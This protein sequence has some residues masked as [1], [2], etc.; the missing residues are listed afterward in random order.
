[1]R[2]A[3]TPIL[4][5]RIMRMIPGRSASSEVVLVVLFWPAAAPS[6]PAI[7]SDSVAGAGA[8]APPPSCSGDNQEGLS[9]MMNV[10]IRLV[11]TAMRAARANNEAAKKCDALSVLGRGHSRHVR[12]CQNLF[13][14]S[15]DRFLVLCHHRLAI[16]GRI[17]MDM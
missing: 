6:F 9:D 17:W 3:A 10:F 5:R 13:S 4:A 16:L 8:G 14:L 15:A 1:M 11:E 7:S 12:T 2:A